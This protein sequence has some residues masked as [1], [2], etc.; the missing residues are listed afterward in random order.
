[1]SYF[2]TKVPT[3]WSPATLYEVSNGI[4][5]KPATRTAY[6]NY[7]GLGAT[8][9]FDTMFFV[10]SDINKEEH[11]AKLRMWLLYHAFI[12]NDHHSCHF[13]ASGLLQEH[14]EANNID[15]IQESGDANAY[16]RNFDNLA[17][18][19][20]FLHNPPTRMNYKN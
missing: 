7:P 20:Y 15:E 16:G 6:A 13:F 2:F 4:F 5:L 10:T 19:I 17:K 1:M 14:H 11:I 8:M 9:Y 18:D 12:F 3:Q